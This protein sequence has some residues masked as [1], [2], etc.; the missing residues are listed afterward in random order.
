MKLSF[1]TDNQRAALRSKLRNLQRDILL[2]VNEQ[3]RL[4][5]ENL[6]V[7]YAAE[8][9]ANFWTL[10]SK[11]RGKDQRPEMT[12][13]FEHDGENYFGPENMCAGLVK[14]FSANFA[15]PPR[16]GSMPMVIDGRDFSNN[17]DTDPENLCNF[18]SWN[19]RS[20]KLSQILN[21]KSKPNN[22]YFINSA[23]LKR[24]FPVIGQ[25]VTFL[26]RDGFRKGVFPNIGKC[27]A[28][29]PVPKGV[30]DLRPIS[31]IFGLLGPLFEVPV[32]DVLLRFALENNI[33]PPSQ[34]GFLPKR[35]AGT[36]LFD[37]LCKLCRTQSLNVPRVY[38]L[39][40]DLCKAFDRLSHRA[41][42]DAL[43]YY[44]VPHRIREMIRSW[45]EGR[46]AVV[47]NGGLTSD[48]FFIFSG[49]PQG[50]TLGPL[51]FL[52]ALSYA[53]RSL[54]DL[55]REFIF[56]AD[57]PTVVQPVYSFSDVGLLQQRLA[58][59]ADCLN[60][61]GLELNTSK[62]ALTIFKTGNRQLLD[63]GV[64]FNGVEVPRV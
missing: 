18:V 10:F 32:Y 55:D 14:K 54:S 37:L 35:S 58:D 26:F 61:L 6:C 56:Y 16:A 1:L 59:F 29:Q 5:G 27:S 19:Y 17:D 40:L 47:L 3:R 46:S 36:A 9:K 50:S 12:V 52:F 8:N 63:H 57:D 60:V 22:Q 34:N 28:I 64:S 44:K 51:L 45:L 39:Y 24:I 25:E 13:S 20:S 2:K 30:S 4:T 33:F 31:L 21:W 53:T 49:V 62:S 42:L 38:A 11:H 48:E 15:D 41:I 7:G 43:K 23:V